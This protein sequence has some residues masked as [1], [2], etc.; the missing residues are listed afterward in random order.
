MIGYGDAGDKG[1]NKLLANLSNIKIFG[2]SPA[3]DCII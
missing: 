3:H 1:E 2:D